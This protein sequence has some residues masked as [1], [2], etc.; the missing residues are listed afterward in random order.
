MNIKKSFV[1]KQQKLYDYF[2]EHPVK[3]ED[4]FVECNLDELEPMV[5]VKVEP[6][7]NDSDE[8][9]KLEDRL[10]S[11]GIYF[12]NSIKINIIDNDNNFRTNE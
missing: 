2:G 4:E 9:H 6:F 7:D 10:H 1:S 5:E 3:K 11:Y 8:E 12:C